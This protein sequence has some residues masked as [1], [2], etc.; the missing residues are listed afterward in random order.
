MPGLDDKIAQ[1][2][3]IVGRAIA[4]HN[5]SHIFGLFSGGNDSACSTHLISR[6]PRFTRAARFDTTIGIPESRAHA[7]QVAQDFQWRLIEYSPPVAYRDL[8]LKHGFPGPG[9]HSFMYINLKER[10]VDRLVREHKQKW[11]DRIML[12][13]G[14]RLSESERRMGHVEEIVRDG[15]SLWV[16][17]IAH[18]DDDDKIEYM[19]RYN[20]PRNP[21]T[22]RLCMSGE[23][24]C[25]AFAKKEEL[26][27]IELAYPVTAA[28]IHGLQREAEAAGVH[29]KWGTRKPGTRKK[30]TMGGMLCKSCNQ[31]NFPFMEQVT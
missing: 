30:P 13:T 16:A 1:S 5:P 26:L 23:C 28:V 31:K 25:G 8:V 19:R 14:V 11:N 27:D 10:C 21:V 6:H 9:A 29:A 12:V 15:C 2:M 3:E 20:L 17:P 18:W 24:L 22:D 7:L 4:E